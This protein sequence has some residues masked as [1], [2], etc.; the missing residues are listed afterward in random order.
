MKKSKTKNRVNKGN[1]RLL[2]IEVEIEIK[3]ERDK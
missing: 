1:N 2:K 3:R